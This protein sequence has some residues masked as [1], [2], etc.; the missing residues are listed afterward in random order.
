MKYMNTEKF[1]Q[2]WLLSA[3]RCSLFPRCGRSLSRRQMAYI[4]EMDSCVEFTFLSSRHFINFTSLSLRFRLFMLNN[5]HD[6]DTTNEKNETAVSAL[7]DYLA[8]SFR[9]VVIN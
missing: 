7:L 2:Q 3:A 8:R 9:V 1:L 6:G 5:I 4:C